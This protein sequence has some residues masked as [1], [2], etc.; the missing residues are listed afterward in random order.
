MKATFAVEEINKRLQQVAVVINPKAAM[1]VQSYVRLEVVGQTATLTGSD[2]TGYLKVELAASGTDA[3]FSILLPFAKFSEIISKVTG[4]E[5]TLS[6]GGDGNL[7]L[8]A[9]KYR[10]TLKTRGVEDYVPLAAFDDADPILKNFPLVPFQVAAKRIAPIVP[11][12]SGK[13]IASVALLEI[14]SGSL[15]LIGTDGQ[16]L[17]ILTLP[18]ETMVA[19]ETSLL[20]PKPLLANVQK[21]TGDKMTIT[22]AESGFFFQ[23]EKELLYV[24]KV[25]GDFPPYQKI[26]PAASTTQIS[27][28][29]ETFKEAI[30]R[31]GV[32]TEDETPVISLSATAEEIEMSTSDLE[33]GFGNES[34]EVKLQ[35][36]PIKFL[37]NRD[38]LNRFTSEVKGVFLMNLTVPNKVVDFQ[39]EEGKFRFLLM[40]CAPPAPKA[41]GEAAA[42]GKK[43]KPAKKSAEATTAAA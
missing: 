27:V 16:C 34:V 13:Y 28:N 1:P 42:E 3:P 40:P 36:N 17:G 18:G 14:L 30:S 31:V 26:I 43:A 41:E 4:K 8:S 29:S 9:G 23:T 19:E 20:L 25:Q 2:P 39:T 10:G 11:E 33:V 21:L 24:G 38:F 5:V 6:L 35:G 32:T 15:R 12:S 37:L 22:L 7:A